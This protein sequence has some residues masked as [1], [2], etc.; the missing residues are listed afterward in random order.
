MRAPL[1]NWK[2]Y[3]C[4]STAMNWPAVKPFDRSLTVIHEKK[5]LYLRGYPPLPSELHNLSDHSNISRASR[6]FLAR[7]VESP[8]SAM[9]YSVD[10]LQADAI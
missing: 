7:P 1:P 6:I 9:S 3:I 10:S 8:V 5:P 4:S 2:W